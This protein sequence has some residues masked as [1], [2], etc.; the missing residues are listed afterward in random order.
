VLTLKR[1]QVD[2][3]ACTLRLEPGT[4]KNDDGRVVSLTPELVEMLQ[5]Q[6]DRVEV[7]E[8]TTGKPIPHLF[9][10]LGGKHEGKRIEDFRKAWTTACIEATLD[11]EG[12]SGTARTER[13][14]ALVQAVAKGEKPG[15]LKMIR[16]DFRRTAVRNMVN[17]G[18]PERVAMTVTGHKTRAVFDRYH[19]VSPGD[20]RDVARKLTGTF[21]GTLPVEKDQGV[22]CTAGTP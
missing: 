18:V 2:L 15:L 3:G 16:H 19:I 7:T 14:A 4:T 5:A 10:H 22:P 13:K 17:R 6:I 11:L 20:L 1:S 12:L 21:S 8:T 9:P